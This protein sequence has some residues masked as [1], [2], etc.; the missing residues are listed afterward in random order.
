[1]I[2]RSGSNVAAY[3]RSTDTRGS[4]DGHLGPLVFYKV[5]TLSA[6]LGQGETV[7]THRPCLTQACLVIDNFDHFKVSQG[8]LSERLETAEGKLHR[9]S[10][11]QH[12]GPEQGAF[13]TGTICRSRTRAT[14]RYTSH[15]RC[16]SSQAIVASTSRCPAPSRWAHT[17]SR[18]FRESALAGTQITRWPWC[19]TRRI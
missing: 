2:N 6:P 7:S 9:V 17:S 10:A 14:L 5:I 1:M 12:F 8:E 3:D 4:G 18:L 13:C 11:G 16:R 15:T 19:S